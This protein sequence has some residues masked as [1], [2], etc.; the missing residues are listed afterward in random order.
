MNMVN[1]I[2][3]VAC[4]AF[5]VMILSLLFVIFMAIFYRSLKLFNIV[6]NVF[7]TALSV[8]GAA[9]LFLIGICK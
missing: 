7:F 9:A 1:I 8:F 3:I 2:T 6:S 5:V 4:I